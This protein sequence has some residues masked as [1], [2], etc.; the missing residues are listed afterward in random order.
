MDQLPL[1]TGCNTSSTIGIHLNNVHFLLLLHYM[2]CYRTTALTEMWWARP[3]SHALTIDLVEST[4]SNSMSHINLA[5]RKSCSNV[6]PIKIWIKFL[7][8]GAL[9]KIGLMGK[10]N[11]SCTLDMG[12]VLTGSVQWGSSIFTQRLRWAE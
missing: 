12:M 6:I 4:N 1:P 7:E 9:H 2:S 10:L 11:L 8:C 5:A 3:I